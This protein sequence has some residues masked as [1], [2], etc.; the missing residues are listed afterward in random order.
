MK[1][2]NG[3]LPPSFARK[4]LSNGTVNMFNLEKSFSVKSKKRKS[5]NFEKSLDITKRSSITPDKRYFYPMSKLKSITETH[6][7]KAMK[8][9]HESLDLSKT[10]NDMKSR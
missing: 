3:G 5:L 7:E 1:N 2:G 10:D 6:R 9:F 8:K 4:R